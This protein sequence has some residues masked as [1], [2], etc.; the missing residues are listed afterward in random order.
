MKVT[1]VLPT[2]LNSPSGGFKIVY[3]YANRLSSIGH[4]VT[5]VHPRN[6]EPQRGFTQTI[7]KHLWE[8]KLRLINRPLVSWFAVNSG[9]NLLLVADL[10]ESKIPDSDV[11]FATAC[12]TAFSVAAYSA[13]KG[14]KFY[15]VQS[16]EIWN[17]PEDLVL[18]SWKLPMHK[19]V[20]SRHLSEIASGIGEQHRTSYIPIGIDFTD[21]KLLTPISE[22]EL[23]IGMLAHPNEAKGT[24][25]GLQALE[26]VKRKHPQLQVVLFGT[27]PRLEFIPE[28][29][30]YERQ[31]AKDRL[32]ELYNSCRIFLNPSWSEGWGL[33]AAEAM[34]CGCAL[35][36]ADNGGVSEFSVDG[37][38]ALIVPVKRPD[39]MADKILA[40]LDDDQ[41]R[42]RIALS[43]YQGIQKFT[44]ER[45]VSSLIEVTS[46]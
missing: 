8:Y 44:W 19:I 41:S 23:R 7:K 10:R 18:A 2:Y 6:I 43:G 45:A 13:G 20:I 36:S 26:I 31:P 39:L 21:F 5:V 29:I 34:A 46:A 24:R 4:Q 30:G 37:Q 40:L 9:V 22:R 38:S 35:V 11:I 12:E 33:P 42:M 15:L 28:W 17:Q 27:E 3:E 32:V 1:F 16:Y 25:D 14:K